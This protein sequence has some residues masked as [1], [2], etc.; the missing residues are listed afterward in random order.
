MIIK[1]VVILKI[2]ISLSILSFA[3]VVQGGNNDLLKKRGILIAKFYA[4]VSN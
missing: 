1:L 2:I 3:S 4:F